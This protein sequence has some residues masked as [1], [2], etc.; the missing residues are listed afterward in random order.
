M[1]YSWNKSGGLGNRIGAIY[2]GFYFSQILNIPFSVLWIPNK[3]CGVNWSDIFKKPQ[4]FNIIENTNIAHIISFEVADIFIKSRI[5]DSL[6][7]RQSI[8]LHDKNNNDN[9]ND[10]VAKNKDNIWIVHCPQDFKNIY[11]CKNVYNIRS[12]TKQQI[13][14]IINKNK[15]KNIFISQDNCHNFY[16]K[17]IFDLFFDNIK[18]KDEILNIANDFCF[19]NKINNTN[20]HGIH[21]RYTDNPNKTISL[22]D[23]CSHINSKDTKFFICSDSNEAED[24][25]KK[26]IQDKNKVFFYEKNENC[27]KADET[28]GW[29]DRII[30]NEYNICRNSKAVINAMIDLSILKKMKSIKSTRPNSSFLFLIKNIR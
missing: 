5:F 16:D 22:S 8:K 6:L 19:K 7:D 11:G 9:D 13:V 20:C 2:T 25:V 28:L 30:T 10:K 18:I 17:K 1:I 26:N 29:N 14:D 27:E 23:I 24:Y 21:M 12:M 3:G 15:N 4:N